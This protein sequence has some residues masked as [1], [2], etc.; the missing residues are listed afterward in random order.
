MNLR[1]VVGQVAFSGN[2]PAESAKDISEL[3][4]LF[5]G[6][7]GKEQTAEQHGSR[8]NKELRTET[9]FFRDAETLEALHDLVKDMQQ[10]RHEIHIAD[11]ACSSGE[12]CYS[13]AMLLDSLNQ[14]NKIKIT[15]YDLA[16]KALANAKEG[17]FSL[18]C[19]SMAKQL[20]AM[21]IGSNTYTDAYLGFVVNDL[22]LLMKKSG[23]DRIPSTEQKK[24]YR[25]LFARF[26]SQEGEIQIIN[27]SRIKTFKVKSEFTSKCHFKEGDITQINQER[28]ENSTDVVLFRNALY[29]LITNNKNLSE[30]LPKSKQ[31]TQEILSDLFGKI[32]HTL[33]PGG[34]LVMGNKESSQH[35][36]LPQVY[37]SLI[38]TGFKPVYDQNGITTIW[39]KIE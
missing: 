35:Q 11:Y 8:A 12:E 14:D 13:L 27:D 25:E 3:T 23:L 26:F 22:A 29:H 2:S 4:P 34:L 24:K 17:R 38:Q 16:R 30:R 36:Q 19:P 39:K 6:H 10:K 21:V 37:Q 32:Y 28:G 9:A 33:K 31:E 20:L 18:T 15:G 1:S 7:L 5:A